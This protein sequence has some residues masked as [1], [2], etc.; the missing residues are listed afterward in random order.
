MVE[1][2]DWDKF[3]IFLAVQRAGSLRAA[4]DQLGV[5]HATIRR[6][7]QGL[8]ENLGTRIF[9]RSSGG[10]ALTQPGE[11]LVSHAEEMERQT[12]RISRKLAGLD[13]DPSGT[14]SVSLPPSFAHGFLAKILT[15]FSKEYP[16]IQ[17]NVIATNQISNLARHEA[18]VSIR[19]AY[20]V[21]DDLIGRRLL[22][23]VVGSYA[24]PQYLKDNP[25]LTVGDGSGAHW[26]GW[27][28]DADW[29]KNSPFPNAGVHHML[30]EIF[31]Q[32][33]VAACGIGMVMVPCFLADA[34]DRL[35]RIPRAPVV[36]N[37]SIW[38]LL[39]GDLRNTRRVR[40][41]VDH[42]A[43]AVLDNRDAYTK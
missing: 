40:A 11:V 27:G 13:S 42:T 3:R 14:I 29:I 33:E 38:L 37:R 26:V 9:E 23:Y 43:K 28:D 6:A 12:K 24:S 36:P 41:F 22:R 7:I 25:N 18:D 8:E 10:M 39:H 16:N 5:N 35:V 4:S 1:I 34:N 31:M 21:D 20:E 15:S 30:P 19:I 2:R 17:V 32:M